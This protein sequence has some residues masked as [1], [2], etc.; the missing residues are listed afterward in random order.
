M[1]KLLNSHALYLRITIKGIEDFER[2]SQKEGKQMCVNI[3]RSFR[4]FD[5]EQ[6]KN[7]LGKE[8]MYQM[9]HI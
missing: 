3:Q 2:N 9:L 6:S 5:L 4:D 7:L 8:I 1:S